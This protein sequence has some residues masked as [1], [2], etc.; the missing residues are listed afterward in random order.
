M[1]LQ[2]QSMYLEDWIGLK[3]LDE[4]GAIHFLLIPGEHVH[5]LTILRITNLSL[6][7]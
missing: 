4:R 2:E 6:P 1:P 7:L 3:T 5:K